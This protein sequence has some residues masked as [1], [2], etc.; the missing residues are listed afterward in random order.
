MKELKADLKTGDFKPVYLLHG[1]EAYLVR[2]YEAQFAEKL[3]AGADPMMNQDIFEGKECD[4]EAVITAANTLPFF[5]DWRLVCVRDA[6]L[7]TT[8][9]KD[10]TEAMA[11]YLPQLP[12]STLLLFVETAVDKRNRLYKKIAAQGRAVDCVLPGEAELL[13]WVANIFKKKGKQIAPPTARLLLATVPRSMDA[14]YAEA[15]KLGD[16]V[17]EAPHITD[18]D[19][20]AVC[21]PSLEARIFDLVAALCSRQ[22]ERALVQYHT[23]LAAKEQPLMVLAMM[24]RQFR[25]ILQ[26]KACAQ[27]RISPRDTAAKLGLRDFMVQECLRQAQHFSQQRLLSALCDCQDT[28]TRIKTGLLEGEVGVELLIVQ[29]SQGDGA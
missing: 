19:I 6:Q 28:D 14:I 26:C 11:A 17:G 22:T 24:A 27:Q 13:R 10:A 23:M 2:H 4:V 9:R 21:T 20:H 8:G 25:M 12:P 5:S 7:L 1:E 16:Y 18:E 3:L 29:Y 15:D